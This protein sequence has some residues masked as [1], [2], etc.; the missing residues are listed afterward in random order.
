MISGKCDNARGGTVAGKRLLLL[1]PLLMSTDS[2]FLLLRPSGKVLE[3][4]S[5]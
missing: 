4:R 1:S 5:G 3:R 2:A